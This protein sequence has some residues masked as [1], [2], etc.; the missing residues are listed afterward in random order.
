LSYSPMSISRA[1]DQIET[2]GMGKLHRAGRERVVTFNA[3]RLELWHQ[4]APF[5]HSPVA[6]ER[7]LL[8]EDLV[9][10]PCVLAGESAL[11]RYTTLID[12]PEKI[13]AISPGAWA[14]LKA[15]IEEIPVA[16]EFSCILQV[17]RYDPGILESSGVVD[18]Y[19]LWLSM[20]HT[21]DDRLQIALDKLQDKEA[22][23][24]ISSA[25]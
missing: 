20:K 16:D 13:Y 8:Q 2:N 23:W 7:R 22:D 18:P 4:I 24:Q 11:A 12:P 5:L 25:G 19:S 1:F 14:K 9:D 6:H 15:G 17:W 10:V 3:N 21:A